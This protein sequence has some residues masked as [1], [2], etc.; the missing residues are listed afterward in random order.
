MKNM[1]AYAGNAGVL[2]CEFSGRL[3]QQKLMT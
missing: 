3:A 2:A 1:I